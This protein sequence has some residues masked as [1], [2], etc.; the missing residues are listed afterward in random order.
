M[1]RIFI[2][3]NFIFILKFDRIKMNLLIVLNNEFKKIL[4]FKKIFKRAP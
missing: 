3:Q 1:F 4:Q 2:L